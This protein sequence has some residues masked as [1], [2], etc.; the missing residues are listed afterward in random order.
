[1]SRDIIIFLAARRGIEPPRLSALEPKSNVA[2]N[3]TTS[4][5]IQKFF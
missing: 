3:Y 4:A 2:T 1:M 5:V